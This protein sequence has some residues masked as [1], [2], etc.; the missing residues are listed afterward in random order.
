MVT[1]PPAAPTGRWWAD[2]LKGLCVTHNTGEAICAANRLI[3]TPKDFGRFYLKDAK[4]EVKTESV[5]VEGGNRQLRTFNKL[6]ALQLS[7]HGDWRKVHLGALD[8]V[9]GRKPF[10]RYI[11]PSIKRVYE[12]RKRKKLHEFNMAIFQVILSFLMEDIDIESLLKHKDNKEVKARGKEI[13]EGIDPDI[14]VIQAIA[15]YGK[16]ALLGLLISDEE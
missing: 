5:A 14:S 13:A 2:F 12:N 8:A 11:E 3:A 7:E 4:G 16:E 15:N 9:L 10:W 6:N 1:F